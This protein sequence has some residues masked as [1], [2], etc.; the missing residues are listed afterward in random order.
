[1]KIF[2]L[3]LL[4]TAFCI[5]LAVAQTDLVDKAQR[6]VSQDVDSG[7]SRGGIWDT[8]TSK[9]N[10]DFL[11]DYFNE[12]CSSV[13]GESF[14]P[15]IEKQVRTVQKASKKKLSRNSALAPSG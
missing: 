14:A 3:L 7:K 6:D 2:A 5:P 4:L 12:R 13:L 1:M 9:K 15:L 10:R 8:I 11:V